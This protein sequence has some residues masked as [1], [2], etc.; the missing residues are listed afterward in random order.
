MTQETAQ[1]VT[2]LEDLCVVAILTDESE[3]Q[4]MIEDDSA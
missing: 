4:L 3:K 2:V 1:V